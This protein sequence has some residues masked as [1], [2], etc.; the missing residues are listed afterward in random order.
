MRPTYHRV[1]EYSYHAVLSEFP[2]GEDASLSGGSAVYFIAAIVG[3]YV[4]LLCFIPS[5]K[6]M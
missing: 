5:A 4:G 2:N 6:G 1:Q 3:V